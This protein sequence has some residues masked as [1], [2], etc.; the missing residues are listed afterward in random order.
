MTDRREIEALAKR[1]RLAHGDV[2]DIV[3]D[4]EGRMAA[5]RCA[6]Q[7]LDP[8]SFAEHARRVL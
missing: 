2:V 1:Y 8:L 3:L 4:N 6:G 7:R 5:V